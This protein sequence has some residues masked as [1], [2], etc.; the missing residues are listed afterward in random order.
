M[1]PRR[2]SVAR[3]QGSRGGSSISTDTVA[4]IQNEQDLQQLLGSKSRAI[5]GFYAKWS[6][7]SEDVVKTVTTEL[8]QAHK[9]DVVSLPLPGQAS[10]G[11]RDAFQS[12]FIS[13]SF[14]SL[15]T[16]KCNT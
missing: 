7:G 16:L 11:R 2:S 12:L 1:P 3:S 9:G 4:T 8:S 13:S 6:R 5:V 15:H 14:L 10:R